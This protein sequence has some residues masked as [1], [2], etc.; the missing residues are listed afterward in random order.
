LTSD[1]S[2]IPN[3]YAYDLATSAL[4]QVTNVLTGA[5]MPE[6]S[7]DGKRLVYVG[8][9]PD[10]FDL[11]ELELDAERFLP[12]LTPPSERA[13][14][15]EPPDVTYPVSPYRAFPTVLPRAYSISFGEGT[16]GPV[17]RVITTG[18]DAIGR[19]SFVADA[20][21]ETR[22]GDVLGSLSYSYGRLP[23]GFTTSVFHGAALRGDFRFGDRARSVTEHQLG[24]TTGVSYAMPGAFDGQAVALSYTLANWAHERPLDANVSPDAPLPV[25][26]PSGTIGVVRVGYEFSNASSTGMAVSLERGLH[27]TVTADFADPAWGSEDTL[28]AFSGVVRG[29]F[30][31]PWLDHHVLAL[32]LS[33]GASAGSYAREGLYST[34]GFADT[35]PLSLDSSAV[36]Q[37]SFVLRGYEPGA[38]KGS[39]YNLANAEYRFPIV[40]V[41]RG[42]STLPAFLNT[43]SG[44]VFFDAGG[45][46]DR[47]N[48]RR[49]FG[50]LHAGVGAELWL[51]FTLAYFSGAE[52]RFGIARGL[53]K[54]IDA[55]QKYFVA[56]SQF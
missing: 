30:P 33:G 35:S 23:C 8:Y 16:F 7:P 43:L 5:Y 50:V 20:S 41:D 42:V 29:Y 22:N 38:F 36:R 45:A 2:G 9:T 10:G 37:S 25:E 11:F 54:D 46:Y 4:A 56:A 1:R 47:M 12:A 13:T 48:L 6:P 21:I 34:G 49:P 17:L 39:S 55:T 52:V 18:V 24:V 3:V 32:A 53:D 19:H 44:A 15:S 28:T 51:T 27:V 26:P 14:P 31:M 40:Y